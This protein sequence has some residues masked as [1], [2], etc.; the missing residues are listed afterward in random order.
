MAV[1]PECEP[2]PGE[3]RLVPVFI[4][5]RLIE[6]DMA[7]DALKRAGIPFETGEETGTGL[8][9]AMPIAPGPGVGTF[10][11]IRVPEK[12]LA[13][14]RSVLSDLPFPITTNPGPWD[15]LPATTGEVARADARAQRWTIAIAFLALS[16]LIIAMGAWALVTHER[17]RGD[18]V[19]LIVSGAAMMALVVGLIVH[20]RRWLRRHEP[21]VG[22]PRR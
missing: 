15:F 8:K 2:G 9:L 20:S 3:I 11:S 5:G 10:W 17:D 16:G 4:T 18:A 7:V 19:V 14:A 1:D 22:P 12:A 13:D 21:E 6:F